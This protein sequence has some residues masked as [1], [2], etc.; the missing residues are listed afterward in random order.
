VIGSD[1]NAQDHLA[2]FSFV[3]TL[4]V[5]KSNILPNMNAIGVKRIT[6]AAKPGELSRI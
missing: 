4:L 2:G 3:I 6:N 1:E 5:K